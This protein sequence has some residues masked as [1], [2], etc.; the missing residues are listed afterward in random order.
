MTQRRPAAS[1]LI[2]VVDVGM[3]ATAFRRVSTDSYRFLDFAKRQRKNRLDGSA[4]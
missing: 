4:A 1:V 3:I 2:L